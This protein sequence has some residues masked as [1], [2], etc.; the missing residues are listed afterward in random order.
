M[1]GAVRHGFV[2]PFCVLLMI[3]VRATGEEPP[4]PVSKTDADCA[5]QMVPTKIAGTYHGGELVEL[6]VHYRMAYVVK[7]TARL[8]TKGLVVGV[9]VLAGHQ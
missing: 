6:R 3:N 1:V 2:L 7:P 5:V 4:P 9:P 8:T